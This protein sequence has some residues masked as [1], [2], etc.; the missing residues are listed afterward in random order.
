MSLHKQVDKDKI[1]KTCRSFV[2]E[3][4]QVPPLRSAVKRIRRK[5]IIY[6]FE[7]IQIKERD[8]LFRVECEAGTYIRTLCVDIG[9]K[10]KCGAHLAE[11]RLTRAGN[12]FEKNSV[13]LHQ[14]K[15]S[16][17]FWRNE[18]NDQEIRSIVFPVEQLL[19]NLSKIIIRDS[20]VDA[21]CH[22]ASLAVPGVAELDSE[23]KKDNLIAIFTIKREAVALAKSLM[24]SE[25]IIQR[26]NGIC[27]ATE[28]VLMNKGTYPSIWKKS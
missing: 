25:E 3:I 19:E 1:L 27:A 2:G 13:T 20:A 24:S 10:L 16:Y 11:L 15:D 18:K 4:Y 14:L 28:R 9:T 7:I 26:D 21:I 22:G 5:R 6:N 12:F 17:I 23:I 8:V